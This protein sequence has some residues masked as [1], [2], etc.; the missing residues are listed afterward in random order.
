MEHRSCTP[1]GTALGLTPAT[2][3]SDTLGTVHPDTPSDARA[4]ISVNSCHPAALTPSAMLACHQ[5]GHHAY[6]HHAHQHSNFH[7]E[8]ESA[9]AA[10]PASQ[11][12]MSRTQG[13]SW[14]LTSA[15]KH[16]SGACIQRASGK[17]GSWRRQQV[18]SCR[19]IVLRCR[20]LNCEAHPRHDLDGDRFHEMRQQQ[21]HNDVPLRSGAATGLPQE[22]RRQSDG[23]GGNPLPARRDANHASAHRQDEQRMM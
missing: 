19:A 2:C 20:L 14:Q 11:S 18:E 5:Q 10:H 3:S 13:W 21:A 9:A 17:V 8:M 16:M 6:D 22:R 4:N 15:C 7:Y 23:T 12:I 1:E